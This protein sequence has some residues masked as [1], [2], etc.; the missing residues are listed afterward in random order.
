MAEVRVGFEA[1]GLAPKSRFMLD[2]SR[3]KEE[4]AGAFTG[5]EAGS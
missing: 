1:E 4:D 2:I 5:P 3:N